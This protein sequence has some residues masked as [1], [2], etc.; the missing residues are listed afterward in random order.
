[1][2]RAHTFG[3]SSSKLV[4]RDADSNVGDTCRCCLDV[5]TGAAVTVSAA[6]EMLRRLLQ[7]QAPENESVGPVNNPERGRDRCPCALSPSTSVHDRL[8][9][10]QGAG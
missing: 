1:M 4:R 9:A 5:C 10:G 8:S 3:W 6:V 2:V 7:W